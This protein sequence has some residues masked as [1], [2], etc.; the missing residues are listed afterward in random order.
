MMPTITTTA[1]PY[2]TCRHHDVCGFAR[3]GTSARRGV[4]GVGGCGGVGGRTVSVD[5]RR[6]DSSASTEAVT[7][8]GVCVVVVVE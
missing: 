7:L 4:T 1:I 5:T 8:R 6:V 3:I 2:K